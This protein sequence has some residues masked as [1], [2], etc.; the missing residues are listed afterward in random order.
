[1]APPAT[2]PGSIGPIAAPAG[3]A[4]GICWAPRLRRLEDF[5]ALGYEVREQGF[6][7][8]KTNIL[9]R[10]AGLDLFPRLRPGGTTDQAITPNFCAHRG[11]DARLPPGPA[12]VDLCLDL[13]FNFKPEACKRIA[14]PSG[15]AGPF[16]AGDRHV[17]S[18]SHL[19]DQEST[20]TR[21][22]TGENLYYMR[23]F[24]PISSYTPPTCL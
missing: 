15:A 1:M 23:D 5:A 4:T 18:G 8:L 20:S 21:I 24:I 3:C 13:N 11:A 17:R 19:A 9:F 14:R 10:G 6:T 12:D 7:A 2:R 22:C 16:V